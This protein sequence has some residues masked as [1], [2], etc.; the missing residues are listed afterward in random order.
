MGT[1]QT[2]LVRC[3]GS[4][5]QTSRSDVYHHE[6]ALTNVLY[7][8]DFGYLLLSVSLFDNKGFSTT[9]EEKFCFIRK[10][11]KE[12]LRCCAENS[13]HIISC[14]PERANLS[15]KKYLVH[16]LRWWYGQLGHIDSE[17]ISSMVSKNVVRGKNWIVAWRKMEVSALHVLRI[18][19]TWHQFLRRVLQHWQ[20]SQWTCSTLIFEVL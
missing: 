20:E 9:F 1:E 16:F 10:A 12:I 5:K 3:R 19:L 7:I 14:T 15:P 11:R 8:P 2:A 6:V 17:A 18:K 4:V 13:F